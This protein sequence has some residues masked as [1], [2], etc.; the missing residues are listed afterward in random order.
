MRDTSCIFSYSGCDNYT[1][2]VATY[3]QPINHA[4]P[5]APLSCVDFNFNGWGAKQSHVND[6]KVAANVAA[7]S[8]AT[9]VK[10]SLV[11]E[12]GSVEVDG[13]GTALITRSSVINSN[14]NPGWTEKMVEDELYTTL[15]IEKVIWTDGIKGKDITDAH[16]DFYARF[17]SPGV[18]VAARENDQSI[19]DYAVTRQVI[20]DLQAATDARGRSL[21]VHILDNPST[22]RSTWSSGGRIGGFKNHRWFSKRTA[23]ISKLIWATLRNAYI[24]EQMM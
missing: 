7:W 4:W 18:V 9:Y 6:A 12:G 3:G 5:S 15:G 16:I 21:T 22:L 2:C 13:E 8:G 19:Y 1:H 14:R 17:T 23:N 10:S 24:Y 20:S 11:M